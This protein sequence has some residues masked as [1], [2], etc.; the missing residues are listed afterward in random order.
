MKADRKLIYNDCLAE[1]FT[2]HRRGLQ[3]REGTGILLFVSLLSAI[4]IAIDLG[5]GHELPHA[6]PPCESRLTVLGVD[7]SKGII[8]VVAKTTVAYSFL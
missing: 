7:M 4:S 6:N 1:Q 5:S 2:E 8:E 3:P